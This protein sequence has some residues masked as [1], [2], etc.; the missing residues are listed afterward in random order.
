MLRCQK[1]GHAASSPTAKFCS[2]C[3]GRLVQEVRTDSSECPT[4]V[5]QDTSA[6][7]PGERLICRARCTQ[8]KQPFAIRFERAVGGIWYAR[9]SWIID[10]KR[11]E[12]D[13]FKGQLTVGSF[14]KHKDYPGCPHC[15]NSLFRTCFS[16]GRL[17]LPGLPS[18]DLHV[19]MVRGFVDSQ[20][21]SPIWTF[22]RNYRGG[23]GRDFDRSVSVR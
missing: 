23:R 10:D 1:C 2:R 21:G 3:G 8:T 16:C 22:D 15:G 4:G 13:V 19:S 7:G 20:M 6:A 9:A 17:R 12:S 11:A 18:T 14:K 5:E